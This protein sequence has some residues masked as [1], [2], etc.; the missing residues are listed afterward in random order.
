MVA[1]NVNRC[2]GFKIDVLLKGL[3]G[4]LQWGCWRRRRQRQLDFLPE[5]LGGSILR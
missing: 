3:A 1:V 5:S 2:D 4:G